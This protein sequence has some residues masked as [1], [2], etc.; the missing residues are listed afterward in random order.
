MSE[1]SKRY[2]CIHGHF[3][4][5]PRENPWLNKV[6][7]QES[8]YPYHDWNVRIT[9]E[10]YH[11]NAFS[12]ILNDEKKVV[13]IYNNYSFMSFD[14][15]PTL[16]EWMKKEAP[17]TY[18][19]I[20][21]A[22]R[23]GQ[24][25][26]NGHGPAIAQSYNHLIMPLATERDKETQVIWG[27]EDFRYHFERDPEGMWLS[28]TAV[29]TGTL[30]IMAR[31][32]IKFTILSP[33]QAQAFRR[34]GDEH[35][36]DAKEGHI[37]SRRPYRCFLPS[38][39]HIDIFF[40]LADASQAVAFEGLLEDGRNFANRLIGEFD[41]SLEDPQMVHIAT[42][43]ESYGHHHRHGEMAL[44]FCLNEIDMQP[45]HLTV[46]GDYLEKYPPAY[47]VQIIENTAWSCAHGVERWNSDC[48]CNT[49]QHPE[50]NQAWRRPLREAFD[51]VRG[52][53][54]SLYE[55]E[56]S[57]FTDAAWKVRN[58]YIR[59]ILDRSRENV[60][61]F[62]EEH[63]GSDLSEE[64]EIKILKLMEMQY[65]S[66]LMYTSC[67]WFFD[68]VTGIESMQD[69][70]YATRAIQ[71]AE[72]VSG[73][74]FEAGFVKQLE[75]IPSNRQRYNSA[76][77]A[78]RE[79]VVPMRV[80]MLRV[81]VHYAVSSLFRDFP[82]EMSMYSFDTQSLMREY[83]ENGK[84]KIV[85]GRV[86]IQ[87]RITREKLDVAYAVLH[88]GEHNLVCGVRPYDGEKDLSGLYKETSEAFLEGRIYEVM[89]IM[90][91]YFGDHNY[92]FWHLFK[93]DQR[94]LMEIVM[95]RNLKKI[96]SVLEDLYESHYSTLNVYKQLSI[97]VPKSLELPVELA[98]NNRLA[99]LLQ[100]MD[101]DVKELERTLKTMQRS[102]IEPDRLTLHFVADQKMAILL[103]DL[104]CHPEDRQR[105]RY[106]ARL[107]QVLKSGGLDP[108][109][110]LAQN[111]AFRIRQE[112]YDEHAYSEDPDVR[113][114]CKKFDELYAALNLVP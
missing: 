25:K 60:D 13:Q 94:E 102:D 82:G 15:G 24:E 36:I 63:F 11:P 110:R 93:D 65:H 64:E 3:Y 74:D 104:S 108:E 99:H 26:F 1:S 34:I 31:Y 89:R 62:L 56:M 40:Y 18:Q 39:R 5:P 29:D 49:G 45:E 69:I 32:G 81:G 83:E 86:R 38:G 96:E 33:Y 35:W 54:E 85:V 114:W 61:R 111:T 66:L 12:R 92:S 109:Y 80:D 112:N 88:L 68:E 44:S 107:L 37:N 2:I 57:S 41:P 72:E 20:L 48:G 90:D 113:S 71:L 97:P 78:Y 22:D 50:W 46:Y 76:A 98:L 30:E 106:I 47:E 79:T 55:T 91:D 7:Y 84:Q 51:W 27:I 75:K 17:E 23:D 14:I 10:C 58:D 87:S 105:I 43:G 6:E 73:K 9:D 8:A 21:R 103:E 28:E 19:A 67:G 16:L 95:S 101:T 4:Q 100:Q 42:D 52:I 59:V 53:T 77:D 70:F